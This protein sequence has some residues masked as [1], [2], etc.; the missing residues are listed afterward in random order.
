MGGVGYTV[1]GGEGS[2]T[3]LVHT[4]DQDTVAH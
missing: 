3:N 4:I 2:L 1:S